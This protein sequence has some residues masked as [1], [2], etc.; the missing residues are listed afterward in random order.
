[1]ARRAEPIEAGKVLARSISG[2][3][4][5]REAL[6]VT[7]LEEACLRYG[8]CRDNS[9]SLLRAPIAQFRLQSVDLIL[10]ILPEDQTAAK[11]VGVAVGVAVGLIIVIGGYSAVLRF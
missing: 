2:E 5:D 7:V 4:F 8:R 3:R 6:W 10:L 1:M 11:A 9:G